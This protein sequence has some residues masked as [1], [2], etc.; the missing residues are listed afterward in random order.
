MLIKRFKMKLGT[1][2]LCLVFVVILLFSASVGTVMLKEITESMKQMATEK[3]KGDLALSSTYIDDVMSGDWQVKNN[4]LYKGQTQINGNEDIVDLLGEKTGDTITIF[5]GDTRVA[6]NVMKNGERAVGTQA[7]SEVIA[8]VLKKGKRF[9]G[10]ADV[11]GSS[12]QTAYMPLKDQNGNII[13]M[14]YT[15]ANQSILASLTQSLFTQFA[16]VLVI[17][18]MVSVILVLVF[19]RKI[20]KRLNAL[21]SAFESAGNGDMTI[22]VSDKTGDEL[23]E[24][25]VYYNKMRM[26]LND[27]IQTVQQSA[28]QLASASQQLSA[29]A[30]E[31]NQAS[32]KITEAVQQIANGAQDQIT[33]IENSESS[34]KQASADIRDISANTAAIADK[35]QLAQSKADI[36]QKEIANV[37]AQMDA[38]HQ[39]I[40][41]SG[42]I[43]HQLDGRSKQIEQI[44]SVITQ[45][46]DQT[47]LLALNAAIEAARAGEQGKGFA[48]VADEV[49]KLAEESQQSAGQISKLII[50]IQKDMNRSA[51]SVEHVKTEAAEG[52]TMIQ[53]TRDAFKEIAAATGEIS[54]EI[55]DLS[56]SVTNIS[57]SAH[58][59]NDS[60]AANTADIK[61]STKNTR[62]A[63]ALTEEQFAAMEEITAASETLSQL[64]E[65]LTGII[66]QFKMINQAE[67][68]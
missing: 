3:A 54:A 36:G 47:N 10:Q 30:E 40:Q 67:N 13:G 57:A 26:K 1:K 51:R 56:A 53:R 42:E 17:V 63:A 31:T 15:G 59:I 22:E 62:Q 18:I 23:S 49:R 41:K 33:R 37:Q 24:L 29:G 68:G 52:V 32:E 66:S 60:F 9:Y 4:K 7:S 64:A 20:N 43:I 19:T 65:E 14:L 12:Y 58:Q 61:E 44:L 27:T 11:A 34:L 35:G 50:E 6:T 46:A 45:I 38:I 25:S 16:I 21:K 5:Q 39:S 28:L 55:S 8:A 48:V 2:I